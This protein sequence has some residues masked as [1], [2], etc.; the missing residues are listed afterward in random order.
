[1]TTSVLC[2]VAE[3]PSTLCDPRNCNPPDSSIRANFLGKNWSGLLFCSPGDRPNPG[4]EARSPTLQAD[5]LPSDPSGKPKNIGM[6][7]LSLLQGLF[8]TQ[9]SNPSSPALQV[10]SLPAELPKAWLLLQ[11]TIKTE[12]L[13]KIFCTIV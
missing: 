2:L 9:E 12:Y 1:M 10:D 13:S 3:S 4:T 5:S 8:P 7:S 6:G 11:K